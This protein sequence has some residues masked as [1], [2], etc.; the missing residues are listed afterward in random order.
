MARLHSV[1]NAQVHN[2]T[3]T[4]TTTSKLLHGTRHRL[5]PT[6]LLVDVSTQA[7]DLP[8]TRPVD[9]PVAGS[10]RDVYKLLWTTTLLS[11]ERL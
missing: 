2:Q 8:R 6:S 4:P 5:M 3:G 1:G 10:H 7:S 11:P 9:E